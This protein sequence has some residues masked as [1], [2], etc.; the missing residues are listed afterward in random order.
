MRI[1]GSNS[2]HDVCSVS[3][4]PTNSSAE[5]RRRRRQRVTVMKSLSL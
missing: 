4:G 5:T 3:S 1:E 2:E